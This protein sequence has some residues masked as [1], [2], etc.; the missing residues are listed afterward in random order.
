MCVFPSSLSFFLSHCTTLT[1][2]TH[3]YIHIFLSLFNKH[4]LLLDRFHIYKFL[5]F[6]IYRYILIYSKKEEKF[7]ETFKKKVIC[8]F[9]CFQIRLKHQNFFGSF[10]VFPI[11]FF[12]EMSNTESLLLPD[13]IGK[14]VD[15]AY[16]KTLQSRLQELLHCQADW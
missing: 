5:T 1:L 6:Y 14:R 13:S 12:F 16:S 2:H 7:Q 15:P 3:L 9:I 4:I 11:L 8:I 10:F